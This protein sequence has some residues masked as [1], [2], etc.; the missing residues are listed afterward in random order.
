M[1]DLQFTKTYKEQRLDRLK[2]SISEYLDDSDGSADEFINDLKIALIEGRM[3]FQE[4]HEDY[5]KVISNI[6]AK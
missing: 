1:N 6:I 4:R 2:D 5:N 3:Y